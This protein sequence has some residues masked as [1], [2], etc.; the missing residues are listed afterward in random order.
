MYYFKQFAEQ[1]AEEEEINKFLDAKGWSLIQENNIKEKENDSRESHEKINFMV[2]VS[3]RGKKRSKYLNKENFHGND[4]F[5]NLQRKIQVHFQT[6]LIN[7][8]NDAKQSQRFLILLS[9]K[10]IIK[11]KQQ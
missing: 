3:R 10:L 7:F 5:D 6:F 11:I 4:S 1:N 8:C 2:K 9:N